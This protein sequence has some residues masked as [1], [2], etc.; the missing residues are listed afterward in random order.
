MNMG[1]SQRRMNAGLDTA[2][3]A[4]VG[5]E[6]TISRSYVRGPGMSDSRTAGRNLADAVHYLCV[7]HGRH[8]GV[9]D[10]AAQMTTDP[11]VQGWMAQVIKAFADERRYMNKL[12]VAVGPQPSTPGQ[13]ESVATVNSQR[14]ALEILSRSDRDG[15]ALGAA[16]AL[17]LDWVAVRNVLDRAAT[18]LGMAPIP[19]GPAVGRRD[20]GGGR[21]LCDDAGVLSARSC[22]VRSSWS[23]SIAAC[24]NLLEARHLA[25][26]DY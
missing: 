25:R 20:A 14:H 18:R 16:I 12:A 13:A 26:V 11:I 24:G 22:S 17:V 19:V 9:V 6:G 8:P 5:Q 3:W 7:L 2:I 23:P 21:A 4:L 10:I 1:Q 15:C